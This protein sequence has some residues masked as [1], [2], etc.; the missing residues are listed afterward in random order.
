MK[1]AVSGNYDIIIA[2]GG[3]A[4]ASLALATS[5]S[6]LSVAVI[7]AHGVDAFPTAEPERAI[8]L[9][10]GSRRYLEQLGVWEAI[11]GFGAAPIRQVRICEPGFPGVVQ[12][13]YTEAV[14]HGAGDM[15]ALGHVVQNAHI[16][17]ALYD[18]LPTGVAVLSPA[19][20]QSLNMTDDSVHVN[21]VKNGRAV[22][23][24]GRLLV[25][26]DG[27]GS[28]IRRLCG[29]PSAGWDHN[30]FGVVASIRPKIPHQG[31][32]YECFCTSGPLAFLPLDDERCSIVWTLTPRDAGRIME[33]DDADFLHELQA[34]AG[35]DVR[36][37]LG[38]LVGTGPRA[39]FAFEFRKAS[40]LSA[41]R[42]VLI[43]NAAHTLHPVAGQGLNLGLRDVAVLTDVLRQAAE[44]KREID[45]PV[46]LEEYRQRRMP[47]I[48]ATAA[49]TEGLNSIFTNDFLPV[50]LARRAGLAGLQRV[51]SLRNWL[52]CRAAGV[53]SL[54]PPV[55]AP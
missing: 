51:S 14:R 25:G 46:V 23:L 47:D 39:C 15:D 21:A 7:E 42:T 17:H 44:Q 53:S 24:T 54:I 28:R 6:G 34:A 13:R 38:S 22:Q 5:G 2:G 36:R 3:L 52:M 37:R 43:G 8:A 55:D 32:A 27:T 48:M 19:R 31:V 1:R 33:M 18:A 12:M 40:R 30:R 41:A 29:I 49:F 16:L 10:F 35:K 26:A 9:S 50:K 20:V 4:G 45:S 11:E